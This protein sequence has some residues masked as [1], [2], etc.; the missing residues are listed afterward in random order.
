MS[1]TSENIKQIFERLK[2]ARSRQQSYANNWR[3]DI[4]FQVRDRVFLKASVARGTLRFGREC[5]LAWRLIGPFEIRERVSDVVYRFKLP[6]EQSGVHNVFYVLLLKKYVEGPTHVLYYEPF[7]IKSDV[8]YV[9][10]PIAIIDTKEQVLRTKTIPSVKVQW[11]HN[12]L[13]EVTLELQEQV[14]KKYPHLLHE[15]CLHLGNQMF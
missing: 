11:E 3:K 10:R 4:E 7:E 5:K 1:H 2:I 9:E 8:S 13:E 14:L 12:S 6:P 15:V